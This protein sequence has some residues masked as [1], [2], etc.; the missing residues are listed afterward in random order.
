MPRQSLKALRQ[1]YAE[2]LR[3]AGPVRRNPQVVKAFATVRR[4]RFLPPGPWQ[5][6][7]IV[8]WR[9]PDAKP[10]WV[11]HDVLLSLDKRKSIN[12]GSPSF[13]AY[14]LDQLDIK[15]GER[16]LQV[17][18]GSGYYTAIMAELVGERGHVRAIEYDK[19]LAAIAAKNLKPLPQVELI[20]GD[21]SI[22]DPGHDLDLIVAFAGGT[23]PP[24]LWLERLAPGGRLLM[25][26]VGADGGFMLRV[27]RRGRGR[28]EAKAVSRVW[29]Y[30]AKGFRTKREAR[31]LTKIIARLKGK[32]PKLRALHLGPVSKARRKEAFYAT[33]TFWLSR[34]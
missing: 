17:G 31:E 18:A 25:P 29:I 21:A 28:F 23:H 22:C 13:W 11:Y 1:A 16:V 12:N 20:R 27:V 5:L 24:S 26:L 3:I 10:A 9:T 34:A 30:L 8:S 4:E 14:L 7:G 6:H 33:P 19:R 2:E 32:L 15:A